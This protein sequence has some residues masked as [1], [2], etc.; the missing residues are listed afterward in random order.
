MSDKNRY[1]LILSINGQHHDVAAW[2]DTRSAEMMLELLQCSYKLLQL[3]LSDSTGS[4]EQP[5][6]DQPMCGI[7]HVPL[8]ERKSRFNSGTYRACPHK[9]E[10]GTYC[11]YRPQKS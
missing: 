5:A 6:I 3:W 10:D 1:E 7:H 4:Q 2:D 11:K 9:N 8:V